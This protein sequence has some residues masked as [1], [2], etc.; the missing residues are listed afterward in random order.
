MLAEVVGAGDRVLT[1]EQERAYARYARRWVKAQDGSE[2]QLFA[3]G[4]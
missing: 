1:D 4:A 3:F 2:L